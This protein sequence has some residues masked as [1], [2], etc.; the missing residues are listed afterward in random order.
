MSSEESRR[1]YPSA[2]RLG[3]PGLRFVLDSYRAGTLRPLPISLRFRFMRL[4]LLL[5]LTAPL[6]AAQ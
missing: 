6:A 4:L 5:L 2:S 3:C 1:R